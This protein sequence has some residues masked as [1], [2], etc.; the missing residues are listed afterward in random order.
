LWG[1]WHCGHSWP[2]VPAS[3]DNEDDCGEADGMKIGKG[4]RSSLEKTCPSATFVNHKIPHDQTRVWT[5]AAAVGSRLLTAW[6]MAQPKFIYK[7]KV[8][9]W[10]NRFETFIVFISCVILNLK[11]LWNYLYCNRKNCQMQR[12]GVEIDGKGQ[13]SGSKCL[14]CTI[15]DQLNEYIEERL[16]S[17]YIYHR[18]SLLNTNF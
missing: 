11:K 1:Y 4:N 18:H 8:A 14:F 16:Q 10:M 13:E 9:V 2:I 17:R 5:R 6:A 3:G 7:R 12:H 15:S